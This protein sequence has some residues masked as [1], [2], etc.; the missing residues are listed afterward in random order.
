MINF[1][2]KKYNIIYA[3]PPWHFENWNNEKAQT[4]PLN[5]YPTMNMK[6]IH[7]LPVKNIAA[8]DCFLFMCCTDPLFNKQIPIFESW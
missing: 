6:E 8:E 3:D 2:N 1:P 5:H 4:N 7:N